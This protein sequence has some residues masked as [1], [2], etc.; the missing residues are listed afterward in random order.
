MKGAGLAKS[1]FSHLEF[2][3]E[4]SRQRGDERKI[5]EQ[6]APSAEHFLRQ[7]VDCYR[8]GRFEQAL[9]FYTKCLGEDRSVVAAWVGQVM[10]LVQL[11]ELDEARLWSDKALETFRNNGELLAAKAQ[12]C[13][14]LKD[15][16]AAYACSDAALQTP[17][18]SPWRWE[19]RGEVLL[20]DK[21]GRAG[22][23]FEKA[24]A[25]PGADWFDRVVIGRIYLYYNKAGMAFEHLRHAVRA[26][27]G[28]AYNW[29]MLGHCQER[30]GLV[31][32]AATSYQRALDIQSDCTEARS[33]IGELASPSIGRRLRMAFRRLFRL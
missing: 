17:G 32:E 22:T 21:A 20:A 5:T 4:R 23:C 19:A 11:G 1:R 14:R 33:A 7:A 30:L 15:I 29:L 13:A 31:A 8:S 26:E 2:G 25:E 12:A 18:S 9:R 3:E 24:L 28:H 10:M 6:A 27:A 16:R